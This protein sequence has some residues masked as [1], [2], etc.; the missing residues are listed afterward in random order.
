MNPHA[1]ACARALVDFANNNNSINLTGELAVAVELAR[2]AMK[3]DRQNRALSRIDFA[4]HD[5]VFMSE[6]M[7]R[8]EAEEL[9]AR[10]KENWTGARWVEVINNE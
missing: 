8:N 5:R 6:S 3:V 10:I 2:H 9:A 4:A 7:P 1:V